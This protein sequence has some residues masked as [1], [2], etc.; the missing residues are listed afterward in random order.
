M[1]ILQKNILKA[2]RQRPHNMRELQ[3]ELKV[4]GN[5]LRY[6]VSAMVSDGT[7]TMVKGKY[8]PGLATIEN[9]NA[10]TT[11]PC[12]LVKLAARFGFASRDDGEGDIF[13]PGRALHGAMPKDKVSIRLF[14]HPV[15]RAAPRARW[16][17]SPSPQHPCRHHCPHG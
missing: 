7:L 14:D 6:T 4:D 1:T 5:R 3:D 8:A 11:I 13:I 16:S 12:T 15:W 17:R 10:P 2:V 9:E